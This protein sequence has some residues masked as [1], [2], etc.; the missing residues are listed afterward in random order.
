M[1]VHELIQQLSNADPDSEVIL[2]RD[3]EGNGYSPVGTLEMAMPYDS[4][5]GGAVY[6][7]SDE[8]EMLSDCWTQD[9]WDELPRVVVIWPMY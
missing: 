7:P 5:Y 9:E 2:S 1:K 3:S 4:W 6:N 8:D